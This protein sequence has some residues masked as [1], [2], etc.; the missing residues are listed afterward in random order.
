MTSYPAVKKRKGTGRKGS[1]SGIIFGAVFMLAGLLLI[2]FMTLTPA[3]RWVSAQDWQPVVATIRHLQLESHRGDDSTTYRVS[4]SYDYYYQGQ[5]YHSDQVSLYSGSDNIG[6][7]WQDLQSRLAREMNAGRVV[8]W[9]NP[10]DPQQAVLDR[11]FRTEVLIFSLIF[12]LILVAAGAGITAVA[13]YR[14]GRQQQ[15]QTMIEQHL[16]GGGSS[17]QTTGIASNSRSGGLFLLGFGALFFLI[18]APISGFALIEALPEGEYA[19][20]LVLIFPLAGAGIMAGGLQQ[21]RKFRLI[22]AT[23]FFPDPMPGVSG[24][25]IGGFFELSRGCFRQPPQVRLICLHVYSTGSGKN[26]STHRDVLWHDQQP[27]LLEDSGQRV[28]ALFDVPAGQPVSGE[29]QGYR[30]TVTWEIQCEGELMLNNAS[31][32]GAVIRFSR[33]W[34]IPVVAGSGR[35]SW[36]LP[37]AQREQR[38]QQKRQRAQQSAA[39]QIQQRPTAQGMLLT[40]AAGRHRSVALMFVLMGV[41]FAGAG[42]FLFIQASVEGAMLWLMTAVFSLLGSGLLLSG[43]VRAGWGL[44]ADIRAG[45]VR[46][47]RSL[48]GVRLYQRSARVTSA[49]QLRLCNSMT[50]TSAAG[51][52][53]RYYR[54]LA[55]A[56]GKTI[57]LAEGISGRDAAEVLKQQVA[58]QLQQSLDDELV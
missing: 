38:Q 7:Y 54:L 14:R 1:L 24:G 34:E 29:Q 11:T 52:Q 57:P 39:E 10:L 35:A 37:A 30:G 20:L 56:D 55:V 51:R 26:C 18:G 17:P 46:M 42:V 13:L 44:E 2:V 5:P 23:P 49:T 32:D 22:G 25:Q 43:I 33:R 48:F 31:V 50:S 47:I 3:L 8:A 9:V 28:R 45:E 16:S 41:I 40:S 36:Q 6:S 53:T 27:A 15:Q 58:D 12:G 19:A 21:L 4:A